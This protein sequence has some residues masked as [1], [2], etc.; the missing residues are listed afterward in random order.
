[1]YMISAYCGVR[2]NYINLTATKQMESFY[3][4][5]LYIKSAIGEVKALIAQWKIRNPFVPE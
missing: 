4:A 2:R 1:M 5:I 3:D